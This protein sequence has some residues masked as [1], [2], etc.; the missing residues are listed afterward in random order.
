MSED[1]AVKPFHGMFA[2]PAPP[3]FDFDQMAEWP[4]WIQLFDDYRFA[5]GLNERSEEAQVRILLYTM[6]RQAREIFSTFALPEEEQKQYEVVRKKFDKHFVAARYLVYE[7]TCFHRH[8]QEPEESVDQ[9]VTALHTLADQCDYKEK[10]HMIRDRFVVGLRDAKLSESLQMDANLTLASALA[11]AR[12]KE[13]VQRQQQQ[14][15]ETDDE[16]LVAATSNLDGVSKQGQ[17]GKNSSGQ[18]SGSTPRS[19]PN[20]GQGA[21]P[22]A[23]CPAKAAKCNYCG[24]SEHFAAAGAHEEE[25]EDLSTPSDVVVYPTTPQWLQKK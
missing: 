23:S 8:I 15:R 3:R 17:P 9:F 5:S 18:H 2:V 20:C 24:C 21:H 1:N 14:L 13:T 10:E 22:R 7:S 19:C 25:E 6:G 4:S 11:K 12:L 16:P